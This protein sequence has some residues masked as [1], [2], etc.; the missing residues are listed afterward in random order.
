MLPRP[1]L[2][3]VTDRHQCK[4]DLVSA[5]AAAVKGGVHAV[6]LREKDLSASELV[7]LGRS[8][9]QAIAGHAIFLV[10][11]RADVAAALG[12]DG[13]H[14]P[15]NGLPAQA[16]R[17]L[18][19][20]PRLVGRSVHSVEGALKAAAEGVDYLVFGN[21]YETGSHPGFPAAGIPRLQEVVSAVAVPVLAIG[22]VTAARVSELRAAGAAG[23][24]VI[25]AVLGVRD[26]RKAAG[27]LAAV[28]R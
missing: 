22:G 18:L 9:Q 19:P 26:P 10:N 23:V 28:F 14:L 3:L 17:L 11:D 8:L 13:V 24:A 7:A 2:M 4:G 1:C 5:V 20:H 12:A 6:Q 16:A 15:E 27:D 21:V 25:S